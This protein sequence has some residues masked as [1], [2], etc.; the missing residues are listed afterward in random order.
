MALHARYISH[1]GNA[2]VHLL[3]PHVCQSCGTDL[4]SRDH[5]LCLR[6]LNSLPETRFHMH[7]AN[8]V[9]KLLWG[10]LPVVAATAQYYFTKESMMQRLMHEIK[11]KGNRELARYMGEL[12]GEA[13]LNTHRFT[14]IDAL[15]PLPLHPLKEKRRGYNQSDLLCRGMASVMRLP[16]LEHAVVRC[17]NTE[18]QTRK[19]RVDRWTNMEGKF[20]LAEAS[21]LAGKHILLVDDV[22]TTGATLEACGRELLKAN[23]L[24]LS[25]ATLCFSSH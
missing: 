24:R 5:Q 16:L 15:V 10:R 11:Y 12:M 20:A 14:D 6:C 4:L 2:L 21:T 9:E 22:I 23:G 19:S 8:P 3:F 25:L 13:I 7:A 17:E 18:S 1:V